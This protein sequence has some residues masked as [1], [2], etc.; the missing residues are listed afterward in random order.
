M[1][2][3]R[4]S[5]VANRIKWEAMAN[6]NVRKQFASSMAAKFQQ[7]P[8]VSEDIEMECSLFRTAMISSAVESCGQK[9]LRM[10]RGSE[11]RTPWW[12][13]DVTVIRAKKDAFKAL[14]QNRSLPDL[15]S[16]YSE[17][18]KVAAQ[19]VKMSKEYYWEE[20]GLPLDSNYSLANKVFWQTIRRLC[21][22][23]LSTTTSIKDLTGNIFRNEKEIF[24]QSRDTLKI[25]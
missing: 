8:V 24:S 1:R 6:R 17:M 10:A 12:N 3:S 16:R 15:Q 21:G 11:K 25:C 9:Q 18:R 19:V 13:K 23:S 14:L 5:S 2:K 7:L 4:R 22:K 20:F